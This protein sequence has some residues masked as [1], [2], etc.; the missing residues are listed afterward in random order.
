MSKAGDDVL[1][2]LRRRIRALGISKVANAARVPATTVYSF[3][4]NPTRQMGYATATQI[5]RAVMRMEARELKPES[6]TQ[7]GSINLPVVLQSAG[8]RAQ[9]GEKGAPLLPIGTLPLQ[10]DTYA[11]LTEGKK[12]KCVGMIVNGRELIQTLLPG[13]TVVVDLA[14]SAL[15]ETDRPYLVRAGDRLL[16]A[17]CRVSPKRKK[18]PLI[19]FDLEPE[20]AL[21]DQERDAMVVVGRVR[22]LSRS[23]VS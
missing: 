7:S 3:C 8:Y 13:D 22:W 1:V 11:L 21:S 14:R 4:Q 16:F 15:P 17:H 19:R 2:D 10:I 18:A 20:P 5:E 23:L 9:F 6:Y 12:A